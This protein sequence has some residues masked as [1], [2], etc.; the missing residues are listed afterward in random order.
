MF[1]EI[2]KKIFGSRNERLLRQYR[3]NVLR[4]NALEPALQALSDADLQAKTA[5]FKARFVGGE[6]LD[7]LLPEAFAV[8]REAGRR[9]LGMRHFDVQLIGGM[10]LHAGKIAEMRTG[11]GKTL[12]ATLPSYLNALSGKSVHIVTVND[13]LARRD[14]EWMGRIHRFLGLTVGVNLSQMPS[15]EKVEAYRSDITYGTNNEFGFDYLRDNMVQRSEDRVMRG[16][17]FAIVDEVDSI[18]IDEARTPLIISGQAEDSTQLYK[19]MNVLIPR[20]SPQEDET[21]S[22]DYFIDLKQHSV[23]LSEQGHEKAEALMVEF[24]L[25]P[26]GSSLYDTSNITL[27]HHLH[28]A[29]RAHTLYHRDQHYVIQNDEA[30]IVDEFTGRMMQGRRWS[31]GLHQAVEAKEGVKIQN[32]SQTLASITFQNYFRMYGKLS[33]MT[34]TA[35]TEAFEFNQIYGLETVIIPPHR[36]MVRKDRMDQVFRSAR[37]KHAAIIA[38]IRDCHERGQPVLVGTTSIE[39]S[40]LLSG[41][42]EKEKLVHQVLNAKQHAREAEIVAQAGRPGVITIATNMA[43]RGTDI[44]LGGNPESEIAA[45]EA[46][47]SLSSEMKHQRITQL[48]SEWQA[49]HDLVVG[50][51][52]LHIVGS[53]RHES[54]RIDNQLRGRAGRQGDPGSSRFYLSLEDPLLKIFASDRV[55]AIMDRL[56]MPEGEAIEH[57]WVTR[58][59]ENAQRKVEAR[60]FDIRKQ[61]LEYDDVSNDQRKVIYAQRNEL[62]E[63]EDISATISHIRQDVIELIFRVAIPADASEE[64]WDI[65]GLM[66]TLSEELGLNLPVEEWL[67]Q[68]S[69]LDEEAVIRRICDAAKITYE[70]KFSGVDAASLHGYERAVTLHSI[71]GRWREHLAALDHLRQGIHLRGYAQKNPKQEYKRE[72]FEL[73]SSMLDHIKREVTRILMQVQVSTASEA[74]AATEQEIAADSVE[75]VQYH[76]SGFDEALAAPTIEDQEKFPKVGR[77]DPCPCGSGKKYKQCH[78]ALS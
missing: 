16:L 45:I 65:P 50:Q 11:E 36:T 51:G 55:A 58:A 25:M 35:D 67:S 75:N 17:H 56:Q 78:G 8:V 62:L 6:T 48:K 3:K 61:L 54:R 70:A 28:A 38:D 47:E 46:D 69:G 23:M 73:F 52:G 63:T 74:E 2:L 33:G 68:E 76:H 14:A 7:Q 37:E 40:E 15:A 39:S 13:Y 32:E 22:G 59:I 72:A 4:I 27:I 77:N 1:S 60:N 31:E 26:E 24:G 5:E 57:P 42:L 21:S 30:V 43:G 41:M 29:L 9:V 10:V 71:D 64:M 18:L 66:Q 19:A 34:G 53:E 12:M 49:R 20:L 44:V